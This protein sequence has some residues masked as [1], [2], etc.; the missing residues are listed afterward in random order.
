VAEVAWC[1]VDDAVL[2]MALYP[3]NVGDGMKLI[4][5]SETKLSEQILAFCKHIAGQS[6]IVA[7]AHVDNYSS[8]PS[9]GRVI[10]EVMLVIQ[11][12][13]P[14]LM[15][16]LKPV[17][18]KPISV[19]AVDQWIFERD[20]DRGLL[21]EALASKLIFPYTALQG[22]TYLHE[23]EVELKKRLVIELL[24]NLS[25][26]FPELAQRIQI[27]PQYFM[28]EIFYNRVRVFPLLAYNLTDLTISIKDAENRALSCY[29]EVLNQLEAE[30]KIS[31]KNGYVFITPKFIARCQDPK[32]RFINL[33]KSAPRTLFTSLFGA[34]P[35]L[36]NRVGQNTET[37][38]RTQKISW[39]RPN[40][41]TVTFID[42]RKYVFFPTAEGLVSLAD[43]LDIKGYTQRMLLKNQN[44]NIDV[45]PAGGILNDVYVINASGEGVNTKILV[46]RFKDWSGFKWFPLT[47][48]SFGAR[49]FAVSGQARLAK[50]IAASEFLRGEGFNVPK[51]LHFSNPELLIF[52]EFIEAE[53]LNQIIK[54]YSTTTNSQTIA[55]ALDI[56][57][58]VGE[59]LARV[60]SANLSLGD[61]KPDN[62][63]IKPDGT[64]YLIDFEQAMQGG[65]KAWDVAVFLYYCGHY[66]QPF[67]NTAKAKTLTHSFIEGYLRGGGNLDIIHK[68]ALTKY[69]R[70]FSI[71][72][73]PPI[74]L[75]I[76]NI[77]KSAEAPKNP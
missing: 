64:I 8:N 62:V 66:L 6:K 56:F 60:H 61:T 58:R 36:A 44:V 69:T 54:R 39:I 46:K 50:E 74:M 57:N 5:D 42:S 34:L 13:Q 53:G 16:Y 32:L 24:E 25:I 65:D 71:F 4:D 75:A 47:L 51:I 59:N 49:S 55:E 7:V 35:Q 21:G 12:F 48:W 14:R 28:Y 37:F 52:M 31:L 15:R 63:L 33:S 2:N 20:I 10:H 43:K 68:A 76:S 70:I 17:Q 40:E 19:F 30:E 41:Q 77:C 73:V 27:L 22:E 18:D 67:D 38:L 3:A 11:N 23:R 26:N 1:W 45:T 29:I 72:T 9:N